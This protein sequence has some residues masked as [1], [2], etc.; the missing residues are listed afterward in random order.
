VFLPGEVFHFLR[1]QKYLEFEI[2]NAGPKKPIP[3]KS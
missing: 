1:S 2:W 3:V